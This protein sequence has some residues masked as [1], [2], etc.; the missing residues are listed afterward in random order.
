MINVVRAWY[1]YVCFAYEVTWI[2]IQIP[3]A[4]PPPT[5]ESDPEA[6]ASL[7]GTPEHMWPAT[8]DEFY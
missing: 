8:D 2:T 5:A 7:P 1:Y 3:R 6:S 4:I